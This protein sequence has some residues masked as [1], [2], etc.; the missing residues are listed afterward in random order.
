MTTQSITL[1]YHNEIMAKYPAGEWIKPYNS[2]KS[3]DYSVFSD[4]FEWGLV[5]KKTECHYKGKQMIGASH[6]FK[7]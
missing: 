3:N 1:D 4:L 7:Y 2:S 6:Y 5:E